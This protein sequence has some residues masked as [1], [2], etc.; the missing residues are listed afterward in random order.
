VN[1][2][3]LWFPSCS[4]RILEYPERVERYL[5]FALALDS[6]WKRERGNLELEICDL[7]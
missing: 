7:S 1:L 4:T 6:E 5:S 3:P 2:G